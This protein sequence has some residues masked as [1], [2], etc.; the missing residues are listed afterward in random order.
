MLHELWTNSEGT[1]LFCLA[2]PR[3]DGARKLLE[4]GDQ[5]IWTCEAD[6]HVEAMT[7]YYEFRGWGQYTSAFPEQ[8]NKTYR[9]MGWE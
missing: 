6:S 8:D 5:L 7:K 1:D 4:P 2:G 3:G 9:E